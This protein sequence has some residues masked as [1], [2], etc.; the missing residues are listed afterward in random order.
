MC[1]S[2]ANLSLFVE[3]LLAPV[4]KLARGTF[5]CK[6]IEFAQ[7]FP[8]LHMS[9]STLAQAT[10]RARQAHLPTHT[11]S[12]S[13]TQM[14]TRMN[15]TTQHILPILNLGS[16][17]HMNGIQPVPNCATSRE[18]SMRLLSCPWPQCSA[19]TWWLWKPPGQAGPPLSTAET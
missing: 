6:H 12:S 9:V 8:R 18:R 7:M 16:P 19:V 2:A 10:S 14:Y 4:N 15:T 11:R 3:L 13:H 17:G 1:S 5:K